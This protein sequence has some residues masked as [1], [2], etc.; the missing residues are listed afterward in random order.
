MKD[1][2]EEHTPEQETVLKTPFPQSAAFDILEEGGLKEAGKNNIRTYLEKEIRQKA[3]DELRKTRTVQK[4][5]DLDMA[6]TKLDKLSRACYRRRPAALKIRKETEKPI[7]F[8]S[9]TTEHFFSAKTFV[10]R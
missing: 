7:Q 1:Q 5:S 3:K 10:R 2:E 4:I 9:T 6:R 8:C